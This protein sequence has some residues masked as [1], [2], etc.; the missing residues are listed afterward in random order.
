MKDGRPITEPQLFDYYT[1]VMP[2]GQN[3]VI[4]SGTPLQTC[5]YNRL[6]YM[7][8]NMAKLKPRKLLIMPYLHERRIYLNRRHMDNQFY[9]VVKH[10]NETFVQAL[11]FDLNKIYIYTET[12][13]LIERIIYAEQ[14]QKWGKP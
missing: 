2:L 4:Q 8:R 1:D 12:G 14:A 5:L 3:V 6:A 10:R 7:I 13:K 11:C 9:T